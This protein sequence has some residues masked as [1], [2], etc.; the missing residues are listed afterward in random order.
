MFTGLVS[1]PRAHPSEAVSGA[2]PAGSPGVSEE[3][4]STRRP[5]PPRRAGE[6]SAPSRL[7]A[8][9]ST[10]QLAST[11][12]HPELK[13]SS[14]APRSMSDA[15]DPAFRR[16]ILYKIR[17]ASWPT[18]APTVNPAIGPSGSTCGRRYQHPCACSLRTPQGRLDEPLSLRTQ[19]IIGW[20]AGARSLSAGSTPAPN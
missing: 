12:K 20:Q 15:M 2:R 11:L 10:A 16:F 18:F 4:R 17:L 8:V 13:R 19:F 14:E 7:I 5:G 9:R 1:D 6:P 3:P